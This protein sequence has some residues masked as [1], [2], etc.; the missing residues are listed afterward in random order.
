M[1]WDRFL[2]RFGAWGKENHM[3]ESKILLE[4]WSPVC[5]IQA[6]VERTETS[7]YFYLWINP[8]TD[9]AAV[10]SC[11]IC[12]TTK[13]PK[14]LD[15][16]AMKK[17][18][19]PAM[20]EAYVLHDPDGMELDAEKLRIVWFEEGN[21]AALL[22]EEDIIC[23]IPCWSGFEGF[24]G[25]AKYVKGATPCA[26]GLEDA[27]ETMGERVGRSRDFWDW[28]EFEPDYWKI[29]QKMHMDALEKFF[30]RCENY[31]AIDGEQFP[32]KALIRGTRD[33]VI[34]GI[35]AGVSL[36]PMPNIELYDPDEFRTD[37]RTEL[38][39]AA[40][41][42]HEEL[43][44]QMYSYLSALSAYPW[45]ENT[46]LAHGHTI[47]FRQI[48]GFAAVLLVNPKLVPE[49]ECPEYEPFRGDA[50]NLLWVVPI[51]NEVYRF[52]QEH[53]INDTLQACGDIAKIHIFDGANKFMV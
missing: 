37:R 18:M 42:V 27:L 8:G 43:C 35:T 21:A 17:G 45:R 4:E 26:W 28:F 1:G 10:K 15:V 50:V 9:N 25:Y 22:S 5:N 41:A 11:W 53:D 13:A 19:A 36:I 24:H 32:P 34:Y 3:S 33:G 38:G 52:A 48:A 6:F 2:K 31:Y 14:K 51:T 47:P 49:L 23:V 7:C 12:N 40:A 46:F 29:T 39:F 30:G 44:S 20:P 16:N